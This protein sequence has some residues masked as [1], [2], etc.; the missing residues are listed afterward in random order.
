MRASG[1]KRQEYNRIHI[2]KKNHG[3]WNITRA[4]IPISHSLTRVRL[5]YPLTLSHPG[6][7]SLPTLSKVFVV[8]D[9]IHH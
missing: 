1:D 4:Y 7:L 8:R 9:I 3:Y 6:P 5:L 2:N